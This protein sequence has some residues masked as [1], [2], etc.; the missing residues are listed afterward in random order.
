MNLMIMARSIEWIG[1]ITLSFF[2]FLLKYFV[3]IML[4]IS[5]NNIAE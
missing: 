5:V 1:Q 2:L 3:D 4:F